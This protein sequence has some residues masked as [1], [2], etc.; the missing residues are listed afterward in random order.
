MNAPIE[1][2]TE[3]EARILCDTME[4]R[5]LNCCG[6]LLEVQGS[7]HGD[8]DSGMAK[9]YIVEPGHK[10]QYLHRTVKIYLETPV[11]WATITAPTQN[12]ISTPTSFY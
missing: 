3:F 7:R 4:Y 6:G 11:V 8:E 10:V 5:L 1:P 12:T 2:F 9:S